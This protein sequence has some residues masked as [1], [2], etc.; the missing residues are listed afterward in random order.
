ILNNSAQEVRFDAKVFQIY[1]PGDSEGG[2]WP[3]TGKAKI[4]RFSDTRTLVAAQGHAILMADLGGDPEPVYAY[5]GQIKVT[6]LSNRRLKR[7]EVL[8]TAHSRR[9]EDLRINPEHRIINTEW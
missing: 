9:D 8:P 2:S 5:E 1:G 3:A 6:G 4:E 7:E